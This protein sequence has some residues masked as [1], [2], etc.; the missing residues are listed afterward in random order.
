MDFCFCRYFFVI[1]THHT[2][3]STRREKTLSGLL[4]SFSQHLVI[5]TAG[6]ISVRSV[7]TTRQRFLLCRRNDNVCVTEIPPARHTSTAVVA[8]GHCG[9]NDKRV[10]I[11]DS[12]EFTLNASERVVGMTNISI[13]NYRYY[14]KY[15][16]LN[17]KNPTSPISTISPAYGA[18]YYP[19]H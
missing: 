13:R 3:I 5:S 19:T 7:K 8:G 10:C 4:L 6:E 18:T 16:F 9:R 11:R 2:V 17:S 15:L 1:S 12:T 14:I